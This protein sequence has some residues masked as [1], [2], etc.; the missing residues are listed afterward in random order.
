MVEQTE[1][2]VESDSAGGAHMGAR[3][4]AG[5][6]AG[7]IGGILMLGFMMIYAGVNDAGAT[8]PLKALGAFEYGVVS[9]VSGPSAMIVGALIE[10]GFSIVLGILFALFVSRRTSIVAALF[11]GI[12]VGIAIWVAMD[13]FV[14]PFADPTMAARMELMPQAYF[15]AHLLYGLG[16]ATS[17]IFVRAFA[18]DRHRRAGA[19]HAA[20]TQP[21]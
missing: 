4:A 14:L 8:M 11:A 6:A 1:N 20:E 13:L 9:F 3:L 18:K 16:L 7:L 21:I 19:Q 17:A 2:I 12:V 5:I 10:L 15:I